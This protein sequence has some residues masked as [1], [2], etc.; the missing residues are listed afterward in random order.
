MWLEQYSMSEI[1]VRMCWSKQRQKRRTSC[2]QQQSHSVKLAT[3]LSDKQTGIIPS[4]AHKHVRT[5][6]RCGQ[7]VAGPALTDSTHLQ[8]NHVT[9][10]TVILHSLILIYV[11][12]RGALSSHNLLASRNC[13]LAWYQTNTFITST[14]ADHLRDISNELIRI[15]YCCNYIPK[16][17]AILINHSLGK[18][19]S[20]LD[21]KA[22]ALP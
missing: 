1:A 9:A 21:N 20:S 4:L 5:E 6:C 15:Q 2:R 10:T 12:S 14:A 11:R 7:V 3:P 8:F 17:P 22:N 19:Y 13:Q 16:S 18:I